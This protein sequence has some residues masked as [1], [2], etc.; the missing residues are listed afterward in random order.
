MNKN[1]YS[2]EFIKLLERICKDLNIR[3]SKEVIEKYCKSKKL[4]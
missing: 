4:V 3:N 1:S 2:E